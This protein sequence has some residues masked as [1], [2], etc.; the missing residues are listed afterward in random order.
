VNALN[1]MVHVFLSIWY[2]WKNRIVRFSK[3]EVLVFLVVL[4]K[5][6]VLVSQT[7]LS[8]FGRQNICFSCFKSCEPLV[9]CIMYYM[10]THT[11]VVPLG[12]IDIEGALLDFLKKLCK[13]APIGQI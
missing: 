11:F 7:G 1:S 12:C 2:V 8:G 6:D 5:L 4:R 13:M 3:P 10:F 9:I